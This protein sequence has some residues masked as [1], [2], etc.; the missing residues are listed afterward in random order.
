[1]KSGCGSGSCTCGQG[2]RSVNTVDQAIAQGNGKLSDALAPPLDGMPRNLD[3][4][5]AS[6]NGVPLH[7]L[8]DRPDAQSLLQRACAELLRQ[9]AVKQRLL[10]SEDFTTDDGVLGEHAS[11]AIETLLAKALVVPDVDELTC[12]RYFAANQSRFQQGESIHAR[13]ILFAVTPGVDVAQL[14]KRA[15][16]TLLEARC[17]ESAAENAFVSLAQRWSNCPTGAEGGDLGWITREDCA[18]EFAQALFAHTDC[19]VL[20]Q[21]VHS[22]FGLHVVEVLARKAGPAVQYEQVHGAVSS[23]LQ[24]HFYC[25]ALRHYLHRLAGGAQIVGVEITPSRTPLVQ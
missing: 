12:R 20:P 3:G 19:G 6:I 2:E 17:H 16:A 4:E 9:E 1:M 10:S 5:L 14:R 18:P 23:A 22:R 13:H 21:L 8:G 11:T 24:H 7:P 15:E 25:T